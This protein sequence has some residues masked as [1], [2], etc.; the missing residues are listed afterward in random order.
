MRSPRGP[1]RRSPAQHRDLAQPAPARRGRG[2]R[3][4]RTCTA[5]AS[6]LCSAARSSPPSAASASSRAGTSAG[7]LACT[8]PGAAVVAGVQRGEQIDH[9]GAA[10]LADHD[11]VRPHPQ[12]LPHQVAHRH[13]ADALDVGAARDELHQVRMPRGQFGGVLDADDALVGG[14][15]A[16][17]RGQ[18][19]G[20]PGTG[21]TRD[22]ERQPCAR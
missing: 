11:P 6:W 1:G 19:R 17:R 15:R 3:A 5:A 10:D 8:V 2:R 20:L 18:Q 16:Q 4:A 21:A 22:Q 14:H 13:L 12:R 7:L 9:L